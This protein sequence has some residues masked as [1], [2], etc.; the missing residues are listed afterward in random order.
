NASY[1]KLG[2]PYSYLY[3]PELVVQTTITGQLSILMLIERLTKLGA[4]ITSANTDSVDVLRPADIDLDLDVECLKW[5][6]ETGYELDDTPYVSKHSESVNSYVAVTPYGVK[7]KGTF[8]SESLMKAPSRQVCPDAIKAYLRNGA[9]IESH[10]R[11]ETNPHKFVTVK[12]VTGGAVFDGEE[13]GKMIRFYHSTEGDA[14]RYLKNGN[15]VSTSDGCRPMMDLP[16]SLPDDLD[17]QW[18]INEAYK[19]L[20]AMGVSE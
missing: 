14:I 12:R 16:D 5:E 2:S 9:D 15:K 8:A 6:L 20:A 4:T 11:A 17:Y 7:G 3:S 1:G 18:Y 13:I 10:I 19:L